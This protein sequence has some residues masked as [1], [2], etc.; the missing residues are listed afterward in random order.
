MKGVRV[1]QAVT[2]LLLCIASPLAAAALITY[3]AILDG[4][5]EVPPNASPGT[6]Q[7]IVKYDSVAHTLAVHVDFSDLVGPTTAAHIHC[8]VAAP[9]TV[10]VATYPGTFPLFP[11]GVT[12]GTY[13]YVVDLT[14]SASYTAAFRNTFGGGTA[15]GA[16]AALAFGLDAG[17]AYFNIHTS[18]FPGG[19]IRGFFQ[20]QQVPE[21]QSLALAG[22]ALLA[23]LPLRMPRRR[24]RPA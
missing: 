22:M 12:A 19:E 4:P 14:D 7:A 16:E 20:V 11:V 13:D 18:V 10:G 21:P 1:V 5:S 23:L 8:C 15:A 24:Q 6:G 2:G 17:Q 9:G 3:S